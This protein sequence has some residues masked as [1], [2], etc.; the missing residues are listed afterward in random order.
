RARGGCVRTGHAA[1]VTVQLSAR[2]GF[3]GRVTRTADSLASRSRTLLTEVDVRNPDY[4]LLPGM[5]ADVR[6]VNVRNQP[7]LLVPGDALV[8]RADGIQVAL[9]TEGNKVHFQKVTVGRDLGTEAEILTGL[10]E[11]ELVINN[12][13][14]QVRAGI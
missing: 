7:P 6:L 10:S 11:G 2:K 13:T 1:D 14:A 5:Y 3:S 9:V 4:A 8:T 12:N